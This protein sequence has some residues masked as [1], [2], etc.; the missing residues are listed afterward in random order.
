MLRLS[1]HRKE[2]LTKEEIHEVS[3]RTK[4]GGYEDKRWRV[5][6]L[7]KDSDKDVLENKKHF[8]ERF[9]GAPLVPKWQVA[10]EMKTHE[11]NEDARR[12]PKVPSGGFST[13]EA[14]R[15]IEAKRTVM[16]LSFLSGWKANKK[17]FD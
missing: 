15:P 10:E 13:P 6:T 4:E 9:V 14:K 17:S 5:W 2:F 11:E 8:S 1:N 7:L 3:R 16:K 12:Q